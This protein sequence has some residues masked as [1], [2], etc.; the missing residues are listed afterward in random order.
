MIH[1]SN[2]RLRRQLWSRRR[3]PHRPLKHDRPAEGPERLLHQ[4]RAVRLLVLPPKSFAALRPIV[5]WPQAKKPRVAHI[6]RAAPNAGLPDGL[7]SET[8]VGEQADLGSA[9][10]MIAA[11]HRQLGNRRRR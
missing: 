5:V 8:V 7:P 6:A 11:S 3:R 4:L 9:S 1:G 2:C 10:L